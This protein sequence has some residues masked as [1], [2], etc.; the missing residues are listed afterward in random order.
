MLVT[1]GS[2]LAL[3][4]LGVAVLLGMRMGAQIQSATQIATVASFPAE[5]VERIE[6]VERDLVSWAEH[7]E[8]VAESI[9]TRRRRIAASAGKL[10]QDAPPAPAE[11]A[12]EARRRVT[13]GLR[14][15]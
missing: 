13:R 4:I 12:T 14:S 15:A 6:K 5:L 3:A 1:A 9:E 11:S 10:K 8:D 7:I 2:L